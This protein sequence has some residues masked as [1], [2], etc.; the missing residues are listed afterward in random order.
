[1]RRLVMKGARPDE[2]KGAINVTVEPSTRVE[3]G[4]YLGINDHYEPEA[5]ESVQDSGILMDILKESWKTSVSCSDE[6]AFS[7]LESILNG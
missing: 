5:G 4:V 1:M 7:L 6:I 3:F 2:L